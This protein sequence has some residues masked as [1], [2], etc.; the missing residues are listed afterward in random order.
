MKLTAPQLLDQEK[1]AGDGHMVAQLTDQMERIRA[2][3][4]LKQEVSLHQ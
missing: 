1:G 4:Q 3:N 2:D